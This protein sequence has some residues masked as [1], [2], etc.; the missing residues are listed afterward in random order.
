MRYALYS[1][2][3]LFQ[4]FVQY[5]STFTKKK[6]KVVVAEDKVILIEIEK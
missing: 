4:T 3:W 2:L 5:N 1:S 6:K